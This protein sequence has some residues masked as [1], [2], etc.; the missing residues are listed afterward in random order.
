MEHSDKENRANPYFDP[1]VVDIA[2]ALNL[3]DLGL[4]YKLCDA[5]FLGCL[6]DMIYLFGPTYVLGKHLVKAIPHYI[7]SIKYNMGGTNAVGKVHRD[8]NIEES[9]KLLTLIPQKIIKLEYAKQVSET[10]TEDVYSNLDLLKNENLKILKLKQLCQ[11]A[12]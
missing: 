7:F 6:S 8:K 11:T 4:K 9:L 1:D 3:T 10:F 2:H 5:D 12:W